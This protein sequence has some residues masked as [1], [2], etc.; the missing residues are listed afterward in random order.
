MAELIGIAVLVAA[1]LTVAGLLAW[2]HRPRDPG[3]WLATVT[4][5][6]LLVHTVDRT[7]FDGQLVRVDTDGLVLQPAQWEGQQ[8][9]GEVWVPRERVGWCQEPPNSEGSS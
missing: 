4:R 9:G 3:S 7:T 1:G 5:R 8:L 6:R 2:D